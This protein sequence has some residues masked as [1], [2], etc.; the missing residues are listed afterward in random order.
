MLTVLLKLVDA[1]EVLNVHATDVEA[2]EVVGRWS[3][4]GFAIVALEL[5]VSVTLI[6]IASAEK[7]FFK[8]YLINR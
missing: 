7:P 6:G 5:L 2:H 1:S 3:Q 8:S 4:A